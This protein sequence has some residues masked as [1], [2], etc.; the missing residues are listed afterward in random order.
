MNSFYL[1]FLFWKCFRLL[2]VFSERA[3][4]ILFIGRRAT[5]LLYLVNGGLRKRPRLRLYLLRAAGGKGKRH[6][7]S[8]KIYHV[9]LT[10]NLLVL[11][12]KHTCLLLRLQLEPLHCITVVMIKILH[13]VLFPMDTLTMIIL[14]LTKKEISYHKVGILKISVG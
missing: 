1:S 8:N 4:V 2:C 7:L 5:S 13:G 6:N 12:I 3:F 9:G 10:S 11:F 14:F